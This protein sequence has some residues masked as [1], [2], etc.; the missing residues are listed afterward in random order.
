MEADRS[1][2]VTILFTEQNVQTSLQTTLSY[3]DCTKGPPVRPS[4]AFYISD[5]QYSRHAMQH[6]S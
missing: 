5:E 3:R 6:C 4:A 1:L 2:L